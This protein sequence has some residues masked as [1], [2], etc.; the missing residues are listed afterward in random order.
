MYSEKIINNHIVFYS[1]YKYNERQDDV[2]LFIQSSDFINF[3]GKLNWS[4]NIILGWDGTMLQAIKKYHKNWNKFIWI[5]FWNKGFL[6]QNKSL[7]N[8]SENIN[9]IDYT[10]SLFDVCIN[11]EYSTT[12]TN[13]INITASAGKIWEYSINIWDKN[14]IILQWDGL[15]ISTPLWSTAYNS[16]LGWPILL[17]NT[18][19][20]TL[21]WKALHSP[22]WLASIVLNEDEVVTINNIGRFHWFEMYCDSIWWKNQTEITE[23]TIK[24]SKY[25]LILSIDQNQLNNWD[26]KN[27]EF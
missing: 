10:Y 16:S 22:K 27:L 24:K 26:N 3:I 13:E 25:P 2:D 21:S 7:I 20:L 9:L 14:K 8:N 23:I 19:T 1:E 15:L 4:Y 6:L 17:H 18:K 5:N 12:F 11:W